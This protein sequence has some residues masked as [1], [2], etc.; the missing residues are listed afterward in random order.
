MMA[1][2]GHFNADPDRRSHFL[3]ILSKTGSSLIA[4]I[5]RRS[6]FGL[7]ATGMLGFLAAATEPIVRWST[8]IFPKLK[9]SILTAT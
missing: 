4:V 5:C 8:V 1:R 6:S 7:V 2:R 3:Q 9:V